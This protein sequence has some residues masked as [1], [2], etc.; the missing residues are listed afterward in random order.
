MD[1][2]SLYV[3][4]GENW[5]PLKC[6]I[7]FDLDIEE[8]KTDRVAN[9]TKIVL[10]WDDFEHWKRDFMKYKAW[11][12]IKRSKPIGKMNSHRFLCGHNRLIEKQLKAVRIWF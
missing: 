4:D 2:F 1:D 7:K 10:P 5:E 9:R 3:K 8:V 11:N 12:W 6:K